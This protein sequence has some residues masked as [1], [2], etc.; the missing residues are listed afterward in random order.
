VESDDRVLFAGA[1]DRATL[2]SDLSADAGAYTDGQGNSLCPFVCPSGMPASDK[3]ILRISEL[4]ASL[5]GCHRYHS[6]TLTP[7][8]L[9]GGFG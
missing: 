1:E 4:M 9:T 2:E 7:V 5:G 8:G 3:L 6:G